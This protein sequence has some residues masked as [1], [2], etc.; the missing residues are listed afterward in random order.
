MTIPNAIA[1]SPRTT[2]SS[3]IAI[4]ATTIT[5]AAV[6]N[7]FAEAPGMAVITSAE[8]LNFSSWNAG[9]YE[10]IE[11][12]SIDV[13]NKQLK[14]VTR[15]VEGTA[16]AWP[17][18][19]YIC[20]MFTAEHAKRIKE[21][22]TSHLADTA[23]P[24]GAV[25]T[26]TAS[27]LVIRDASGRARFADP[28]D[29]ADAATKGYVDGL[30]RQRLAVLTAAGAIPA[31]MDGAEKEQIEG[32]YHDYFVCAFPSGET[33]TYIFFHFVVPPD[34]QTGNV[35]VKI[36]WLAPTQTSGNV[37]WN[38]ATLGRGSNVAWDSSLGTVRS[39]QQTT[40]TTAKRV[41]ICAFD[42]FNPGWAA[43][44]VVIVKI[45]RNGG[46]LAEAAHFL[47]ASIEYVG[48]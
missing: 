35:T 10:T 22:I 33:A 25:S 28:S 4:G 8:N 1:Y 43:G 27:K 17:S 18:G 45:S 21:E 11:Y 31:T 26:A 46:T 13:N 41:N 47:Q 12:G 34:Y 2:L 16:K 38:L 40:A 36:Y 42:A 37:T 23:A 29:N 15:A 7:M 44:D 32:T 3:A 24:H 48:R 39:K 9:D 19:S 6:N 14:N 5:V 30:S 20:C